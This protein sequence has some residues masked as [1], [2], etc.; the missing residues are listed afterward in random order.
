MSV[1]PDRF[2][3]F[4]KPVSIKDNDFMKVTKEYYEFSRLWFT[5]NHH[6]RY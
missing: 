5:S 2:C 3:F 6:C 4:D 1:I